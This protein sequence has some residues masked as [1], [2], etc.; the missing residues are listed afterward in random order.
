MEW[1]HEYWYA[2]LGVVAGGLYLAY[3]RRADEQLEETFGSQWHRVKYAAVA[4]IP[5]GAALLLCA[6]VLS[7]VLDAPAI[8]NYFFLP[9]FQVLF[10]VILFALCWCLAPYLRRAISLD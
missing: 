3:R 4:C 5:I 8:F 2:V 6:A 9:Q 7:V 1:L 10:V